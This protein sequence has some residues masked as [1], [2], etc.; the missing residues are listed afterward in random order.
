MKELLTHLHR[1][2]AQS[3]VFGFTS[4]RITNYT[5]GDAFGP[6]S[7]VLR[8]HADVGLRLMHETTY[9]FDSE[10]FRYLAAHKNGHD[11]ENFDDFRRSWEQSSKETQRLLTHFTSRAPHRV[12]DTL[13]LNNARRLIQELTKPMAEG[14]CSNINDKVG[15][16]PQN[17][18][19]PATQCRKWFSET[20]TWLRTKRRS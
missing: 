4:S 6:L 16:K 20:W 9:C 7:T 12:R 10:G 8:D 15:R 1:S 5:P 19:N 17:S 3:M 18:A 11:M 2:A 13:S 14:K